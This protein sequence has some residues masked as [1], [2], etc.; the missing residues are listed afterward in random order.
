MT[1]FLRIFWERRSKEQHLFELEIF[2]NTRNVLAVTF[3]QFNASLENTVLISL[4]KAFEQYVIITQS[5]W[6]VYRSNVC[7]KK[8]RQSGTEQWQIYIY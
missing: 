1:L 5:T 3:G 2:C 7:G 6:Y 4:K 8:V